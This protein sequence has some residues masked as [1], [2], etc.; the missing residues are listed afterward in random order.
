MI[1]ICPAG[2]QI[3][4]EHPHIMTVRKSLETISG[5]PCNGLN[6]QFAAKGF[7]K[8]VANETASQKVMQRPALSGR[9]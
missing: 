1:A 4:I 3:P 5:M 7:P 2:A 8:T 9:A 6:P